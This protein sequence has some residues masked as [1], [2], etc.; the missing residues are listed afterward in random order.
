MPEGVCLADWLQADHGGCGLV[1]SED[2]I[3]CRRLDGT[4][5]QAGSQNRRPMRA[6]VRACGETTVFDAIDAG[7]P[8]TEALRIYTSRHIAQADTWLTQTNDARVPDIESPSWDK[9]SWR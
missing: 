9:A 3:L 4:E 1:R 8:F 6:H 7:S 5:L 2:R